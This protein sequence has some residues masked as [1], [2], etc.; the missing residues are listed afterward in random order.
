GTLRKTTAMSV[1]TFGWSALIAPSTLTSPNS[2]TCPSSFTVARR[3][4]SEPSPAM[5]PLSAWTR[6]AKGSTRLRSAKFIEPL[7]SRT[8]PIVTGNGGLGARPARLAGCALGTDAEG[9]AGDGG[10]LTRSAV[11]GLRLEDAGPPVGV[12]H[13]DLAD[14]GPIGCQAEPHRF[15]MQR[16]PR[17]HRIRERGFHHGQPLDVGRAG[18]GHRW[19]IGAVA[20]R[21]L[22]RGRQ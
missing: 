2:S 21:Q 10:F 9:G 6:V 17:E 7:S 3:S 18:V 8:R 22:P 12:A 4:G 1:K 5:T 11:Q 15:G 13:G 20:I 14:L 16:L 19:T